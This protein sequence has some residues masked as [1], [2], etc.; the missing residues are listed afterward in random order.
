MAQSSCAEREAD[1]RTGTN[2]V[3]SKP[4]DFTMRAC[5]PVAPPSITCRSLLKTFV[6]HS[7]CCG[8]IPHYGVTPT[9]PLTFSG[10]SI[11]LVIVATL[12]SYIPARRAARV[13]PV[14]ALRYE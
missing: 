6:T 14:N 13:D 9:D 1:G 3:A 5:L 8:G 10:V 2:A 12:A 4:V 11:F 7:A